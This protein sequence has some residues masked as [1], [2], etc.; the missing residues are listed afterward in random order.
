MFWQIL[1]DLLPIVYKISMGALEKLILV[2][3]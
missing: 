2:K 3:S 1:V